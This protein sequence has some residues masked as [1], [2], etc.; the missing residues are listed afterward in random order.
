MQSLSPRLAVE[1]AVAHRFGEVVGL[2]AVVSTGRELQ[3]VDDF[4]QH[5]HILRCRRSKLSH[6]SWCHLRIAV[7][8]RVI[9]ETLLLNL[10]RTD[11]TLTNDRGVLARL[12]A[13]EFIETQRRY[14]YLNINSIE[15]GPAYL[16][17]VLVDL[18][19]RALA[20]LGRMII[21]AAGARIHGGDEHEIARIFDA[22]LGACDGDIT[23]L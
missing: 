11:D 16:V 7:N 20:V 17:E 5:S 12:C 8:T 6:Q 4:T 19:R 13:T 23:V 9:T 2:D 18:S 15:K 14:L 1:V 10:T 21:V 22:V 3:A